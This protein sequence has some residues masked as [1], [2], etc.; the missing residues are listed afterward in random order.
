MRR[1]TI[2]QGRAVIDDA[3]GPQQAITVESETVTNVIKPPESCSAI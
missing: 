1:A 3:G 2:G